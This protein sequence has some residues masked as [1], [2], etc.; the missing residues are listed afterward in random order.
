MMGYHNNEKTT[1]ETLNSKG[2]LLTGDVG[3]YDEDEYFFMVDRTKELI[4]VK[5]NQV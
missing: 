2:W 3:Y 1:K 4:K 5:G